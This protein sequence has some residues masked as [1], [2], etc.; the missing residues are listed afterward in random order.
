K[1][2][3][4]A[5]A[6]FFYF[7]LMAFAVS[8]VDD[9]SSG[10]IKTDRY[11]LTRMAPRADQVDP[12]SAII[13]IS[14]SPS[15]TTI[16]DALEELLDGTGYRLVHIKGEYGEPV[17]KILMAQS[18]PRTLMQMGPV[19]LRD[20]L[21]ALG[22][23]AWSLQH[24]ELGREVWFDVQPSFEDDS[25]IRR[26]LA[27]IKTEEA[28]APE[29]PSIDLSQRYIA[30]PAG[31]SDAASIDARERQRLDDIAALVRQNPSAIDRLIVKGESQSTDNH[32][33]AA[34]A[35]RR[36]GEIANALIKRG[37]PAEKIDER[38]TFA[39]QAPVNRQ[40]A[41][42]DLVA[43]P[44]VVPH[45]AS[46]ARTATAKMAPS[47]DLNDTAVVQPDNVFFLYPGEDLEIALRR[48]AK[49]ALYNDVVWNV[50]DEAGNFVRVPIRAGATFRCEFA[51]CLRRVKEAYATAP[52]PLYFD[53][54]LKERNKILYV[55]LL[56]Y[57]D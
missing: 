56:H 12:L 54:A 55:E 16:G 25:R 27:L 37:V 28:A 33:T 30:F 9:P 36:A 48:W 8:A 17:D 19:S 21:K 52:R 45:V 4:A 31:K 38:Y 13:N 43:T 40:G 18:L 50:R 57:G 46:G 14:F 6:A 35:K 22:G 23:S 7:P 11:T 20:A 44:E 1:G 3:L 47:N 5:A 39:N 42:V 51:E 34:L 24:N 15:V 32:A 53:I 10:L 2:A 49:Q 29:K 41:Y 26:L